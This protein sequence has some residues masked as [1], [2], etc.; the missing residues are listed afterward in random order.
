MGTCGNIICVL[1]TG[2][3]MS[4]VL[5]FTFKFTLTPWLG[6]KVWGDAKVDFMLAHAG[7]R[8]VGYLVETKFPM[9]TEI[10]FSKY[11]IDVGYVILFKFI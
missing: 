10:V 6:A 9:T 5:C 3:C 7:I 2:V 1:N 11:P 8:L 4:M